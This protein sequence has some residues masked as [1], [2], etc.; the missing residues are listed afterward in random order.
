LNG[1]H[2]TEKSVKERMGYCF[3]E[4]TA[5][6]KFQADGKTLDEVF[7]SA[8][9]AMFASII[10]IE[11]VVP[12]ETR[13]ITAKAENLED[14]LHDWLAELLFLFETDGLV[15]SKFKAHVDEKKME[16][17]GSANGETLQGKHGLHGHIK[18]IT[19]HELKVEK[20]DGWKATV[21]LDV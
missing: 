15:F 11:K 2:I 17:H 14:L 9:E 6:V 10:E 18:A 4:H 1:N 12:I 21:I 20:K 13:E 5:D 8:A 16:A 3:L 19:Y 7:E